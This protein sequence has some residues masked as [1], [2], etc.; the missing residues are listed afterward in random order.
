MRRP[1]RGP[2]ELM[3]VTTLVTMCESP[4]T[5]TRIGTTQGIFTLF[6]YS[7]THAC[8]DCVETSRWPC[9]DISPGTWQYEG[10]G[11]QDMTP[12]HTYYL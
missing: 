4:Q 9:L 12:V 2:S 7:W 10:R 5:P 3:L 1:P 6:W 8:T 11:E